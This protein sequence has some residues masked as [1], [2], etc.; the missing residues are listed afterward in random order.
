MK[1]LTFEEKNWQIS[2]ENFNWHWEY[3][4]QLQFVDGK[5]L[6]AAGLNNFTCLSVLA[7]F[8]R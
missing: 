2:A 5:N 7:F 4:E 1:D 8:L 3:D 6:K